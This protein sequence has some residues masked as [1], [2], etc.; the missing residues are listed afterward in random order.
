MPRSL[1]EL[2]KRRRQSRVP[3]LFVVILLAT[4][5]L[6]CPQHGD[7]PATSERQAQ[8]ERPLELGGGR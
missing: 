2:D 8:Q 1:D 6:R 3:L 7:E 4:L 5:A